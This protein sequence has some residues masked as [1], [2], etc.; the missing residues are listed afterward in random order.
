MRAKSKFQNSFSHSDQWLVTIQSDLREFQH[1]TGEW[2]Y[3]CLSPFIIIT[4]SESWYSCCIQR[5][6]A[7]DIDNTSAEV[8]F[9]FWQNKLLQKCQPN[10][11]SGIYYSKISMYQWQNKATFQH[12]NA[13]QVSDATSIYHHLLLLLSLKADTHVG[14]NVCLHRTLIIHLQ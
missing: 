5:A 10:L 2:C 9:L 14:F 13:S 6:S 8:Y 11:H 4:Q 12:S 3:I 1:R 7:Q